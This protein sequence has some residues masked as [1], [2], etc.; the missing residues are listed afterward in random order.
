MT[1]ATTSRTR[2][3]DTLI[4]R[5]CAL[6]AACLLVAVG[7]VTVASFRGDLADTV[8]V[9]VHTP[10]AGLAMS[11][12]SLVTRHGV[13]VG[14][15]TSVADTGDGAVVR[16]AVA[17]DAARSVPV[18]TGV[19]ISS[20]TVFGA[21]A[22]A[23]TDP[24][25]TRARGLTRGQTIDADSVSV[26]VD[27]VFESLTRVLGAVEP[28]KLNSV[29]GA[30]AG[31]LRGNGARLGAAIDDTDAV[32]RSVNARLPALNRDLRS[33]A[34]TAEIYAG[35][36]DDLMAS[37]RNLTPTARTLDERSGD[38]DAVL[39]SAIGLGD[40]GNRV[41]SPNSG[42]LVSAI[43]LL[44]PTAEL[45]ARYSP[46]F[47]CF[48]KG[49]DLASENAEKVSGG[50]GSTML[51]NSTIVLGAAPYTYPGNLPKVSA[52][53]G[54]RCGALPRLGAGDIPAPYVV[55][56]TGANPYADRPTS[57]RLV[58]GPILQLLLGSDWAGRR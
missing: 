5:A 55:A 7:Y 33:G 18:D 24:P 45:L 38:L 9:S 32:V 40:S 6:A 23:L 3:S 25:V 10:R 49:A 41:L 14:R 13:A 22:V 19:D 21:K 48:L 42:A 29:L 58:N 51:L 50:N 26:E 34:T 37:L 35:S 54:P 2:V 43:Q 17:A 4:T 28:A 20:P 30:L 11:P 8:T 47:S 52:G 36:A 16:I 12:G 44:Q 46:E 53:G 39:M 27:T 31:A 57:P 56:D 15:V 1:T